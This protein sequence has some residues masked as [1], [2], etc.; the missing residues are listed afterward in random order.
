MY[1]YICIIL[2]SSE[3]S[4]EKDTTSSLVSLGFG[5]PLG[6]VKL[7][8]DAVFNYNTSYILAQYKAS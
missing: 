6:F 1:S 4:S 8:S 7:K 5:L 3:L 2:P